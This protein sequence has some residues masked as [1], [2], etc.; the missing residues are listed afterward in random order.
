[1]PFVWIFGSTFLISLIAFVGMVTLFFREA[2][3]K[4]ILLALVALSAGALMGGAFLH[5]LPEAIEKSTEVTMFGWALGGFILFF[6]IEKVLHWHHCHEV[7]HPHTFGYMNLIGD[8]IH[9]FT[10]GLIMAASFIVS[11]P[12]GIA[13]TLAIAFHEIPQEI[14]DFGVLVYSGFRKFRALILNFLVAL[15]VV[16]GGVVGYIISAYIEQSIVFLLPLAAGGFIYIASSDLIPEIRKIG[17]IK[18]S[19][20]TFVVFLAGILLMWIARF[21]FAG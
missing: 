7:R 13:T 8:A 18:K 15:T 11:V 19:V 16:F 3:L 17:E 4:K 2:L 9:N 12:L 14:G 20:L 6:L 21:G 1:M 5:L 10:D